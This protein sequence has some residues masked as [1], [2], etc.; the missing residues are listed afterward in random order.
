M[1]LKKI[2]SNPSDYN[3]MTTSQVY[4]RNISDYSLLTADE[5]VT[6]ANII[7]H[8]TPDESLEAKKKLVQ[9]NLRL[10]VKITH[11]FMERG[12]S[13][14]DLISE[15][16]IGL[17]T[18]AEK[19]DPAFGVKFSTYSI[20]WIKQSMR[21]AIAD[22]SRTIRI[23]IQSLDKINR[24]QRTERE[25]VQK[26]GRIPTDQE[27]SEASEISERTIKMLRNASVSTSSLNVQASDEMSLE[28]QDMI[29]YS[30]CDS[31]EEQL[32]ESEQL[33]QLRLIIDELDEQEQ[34]VIRMRYGIG[35]ERSM[36]LEEVG[37]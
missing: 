29:N 2:K 31:P 9:A 32:Q 25:L 11:E 30:E 3:P 7:R 14:H 15:G 24:I 33:E 23:P 18:A 17:M 5:E 21:R 20:W 4:I 28:V 10:V 27:I 6:L 13:K 19:F 37:E 12:L 22:Q 26:L 35:V 16:N 34:Q 36:T 8:G 1:K